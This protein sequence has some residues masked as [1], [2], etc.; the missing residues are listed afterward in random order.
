MRI[1]AF[2]WGVQPLLMV[3]Q[4]L[5]QI[6]RIGNRL[7]TCQ[8]S[9]LFWKVPVAKK[10]QRCQQRTRLKKVSVS[11]LCNGSVHEGRNNQPSTV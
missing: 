4:C 8:W 3:T 10:L 9:V 1:D 11:F 7:W 5:E 6:Q 2:L